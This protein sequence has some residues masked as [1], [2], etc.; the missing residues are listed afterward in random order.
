MYKCRRAN[1]NGNIDSIIFGQYRKGYIVQS[2]P[3]CNLK[4]D[5]NHL[6]LLCSLVYFCEVYQSW[7]WR[8]GVGLLTYMWFL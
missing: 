8:Y 1:Y 4:Y 3:V 6:E 2:L 7:H 5:I